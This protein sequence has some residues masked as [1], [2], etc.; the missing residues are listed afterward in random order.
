MEWCIIYDSECSYLTRFMIMEKT[1]ESMFGDLIQQEVRHIICTW[2]I[3]Y[4]W[5][6]DISV[7]DCFY[8]CNNL[9]RSI[10]IIL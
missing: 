6:F 9:S 2:H 7:F 10:I 1:F 8:L 5:N 4:I 3:I